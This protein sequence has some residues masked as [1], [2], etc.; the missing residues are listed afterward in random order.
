MRNNEKGIAT[1]TPVRESADARGERPED[2][3]TRHGHDRS[4]A[5]ETANRAPQIIRANLKE[6][7]LSPGARSDS[8][9][10]P[11][12]RF[13]RRAP[14]CLDRS[15]ALFSA[16]LPNDVPLGSRTRGLDR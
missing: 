4:T 1:Q 7:L 3:G 15:G 11:R 14:L 6:F 5:V 12:L 2:V 9:I 13:S 8:L 10:P 16:K